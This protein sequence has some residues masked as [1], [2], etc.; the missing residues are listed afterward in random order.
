[1]KKRHSPRPI[2]SK[3]RVFIQDRRTSQ[4]TPVLLFYGILHTPSTQSGSSTPKAR[5]MR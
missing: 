5:L 4:Q 3:A 2:R 1:M